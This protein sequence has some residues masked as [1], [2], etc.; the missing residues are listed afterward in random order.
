MHSQLKNFTRF[1]PKHKILPKIFKKLTKLLLIYVTVLICLILLKVIL[2]LNR[3][4]FILPGH[5]FIKQKSQACVVI[6]YNNFI[7]KS[8]P[9]YFFPNFQIPR[10]FDLVKKERYFLNSSCRMLHQIEKIRK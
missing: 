2:L 4:Q 6:I 7:K 8:G 10:S 9:F 5:F 1:S 3:L